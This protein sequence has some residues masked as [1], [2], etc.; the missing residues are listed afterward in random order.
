GR[1]LEQIFGMDLLVTNIM[2][3]LVTGSF[4]T[5]AWMYRG[6]AEEGVTLPTG[7]RIEVPVA[8]ANFP[9]DIIRNPPRSYAEKGYN[10]ARW[11]DFSKGGHFAALE[12]PAEL[13][14]DIRAF[15]PSVRERL[16]K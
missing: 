11:T 16:R 13:L 4:N 12:A 9:K 5:A 2:I 3:Y 15:F 8:V 1:S 14:D 10:I 6:A 7:K